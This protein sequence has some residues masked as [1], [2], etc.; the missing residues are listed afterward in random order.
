MVYGMFTLVYVFQSSSAADGVDIVHS[1]NADISKWFL[2]LKNR[3]N[4]FL[5]WGRGY[6]CIL[7]QSSKQVSDF[8]FQFEIWN[9]VYCL[10]ND[11]RC[12]SMT[13]QVEIQLM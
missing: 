8:L 9:N 5:N 10:R 6:L 4:L 7:Y 12:Q 1:G 13:L 3:G 11:V 2:T